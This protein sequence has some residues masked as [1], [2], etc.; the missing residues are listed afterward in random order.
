MA[1]TKLFQW[2]NDSESYEMMGSYHVKDLPIYEFQNRQDDFYITLLN[3]MFFALD[4]VKDNNYTEIEDELKE[5]AKGLLVFSDNDTQQ[6]FDYI[7][8]EANHLYVAA[9]FYLIGYEAVASLLLKG[10]NYKRYGNKY[11]QTLCFLL[12][13]GPEEVDRDKIAEHS[14]IWYLCRYLASGNSKRLFHVIKSVSDSCESFLFEDLDEFFDSHILLHVLRKFSTDNLWHDLKQYDLGIEWTDYVSFSRQQG[15]LQ[16][17]KSQRD[18]IGKGLL[19]FEH[20]FSLKMPTSAGKSYITE[21]LVFCEIRKNPGAKVLYLAPLRSLSHELKQRYDEVGKYL[22]FKCDAAYGGNSS[23]LN[24]ARLQEASVFIT[25]P[26]FFS[27]MEGGDE[28]ILDEYTLVICDEGQLL[29]SVNRGVH[30]EL[31]LSRIKKHG[32]ARFLFISA[33]IPNIYEVNTW[34]GGNRNQVG[35]S[36]YRPCEIK[37]AVAEKQNMNVCLS[38][39]NEDYSSVKY[40]IP[41]FLSKDENKS[42]KIGTKKTM[43]AALALKASTA[44]STL[45]F[46]YSKKGRYGCQTLC[47]ELLNISSKHRYGEHLVDD[48]NQD[49]LL[50]LNEYVSFQYGSNYPLSV[51]LKNGLAYHNGALPQDVREYIEDYY[52]KK[53]IRL[54]VSNSTLAEGVNLPI[55]TLV[56]YYLAHY[57]FD[58]N[59]PELVD[60]TE[61]RN[62]LGRVGRAGREKYGLVILPEVNEDLLN[63]VVVALKGEGIHNI[64]GIFFELIQKISRFRDITDEDLNNEIEKIGASTAIDTMI[65]RNYNNGDEQTVVEESISDSLAYHL[66]DNNSK[67]VIRKAY[68]VRYR[69]MAQNVSDSRID[70]L[71]MTGLDVDDF[72]RLEGIEEETINEKLNVALLQEDIFLKNIHSII[73]MMPSMGRVIERM[74]D[75][76]EKMAILDPDKWLIIVKEWMNGNQYW[77]IAR[78]LDLTIDNVLNMLNHIQYHFCIRLQGLIRYLEGKYEYEDEVLQYLPDCLR[79]GISKEQ[80]AAMIRSGLNDRI[81]LHIL[82]KFIDDNDIYWFSHSG[83]RRILRERSSEVIVYLINQNIPHLSLKKVKKWLRV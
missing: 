24:R 6:K 64:N 34:L 1:D 49:D 43:A 61:I 27:S 56:V 60:S 44:G 69:K 38:V 35:D 18:A 13:G 45:V 20:S 26:E 82:G 15:V 77:E 66:S 3:R 9:I 31:L 11:A 36:T 29:D 53:K 79:Y 73:Y 8:K 22:D 80:H 54:L 10:K 74:D 63:S 78:D 12:M 2:I 83:L 71:K 5:I 7:D 50:R 33:I 72:V 51:F 47:E 40:T 17:L 42:I 30:Y 28:S 81:A 76:D 70:L 16:F 19:T 55:R 59:R 39:Y 67:G 52:R 25:T 65:L 46:T 37:L 41:K 4:E 14:L 57:N 75:D 23:T 62:I 58:K 32:R 48:K 21:L 68:A